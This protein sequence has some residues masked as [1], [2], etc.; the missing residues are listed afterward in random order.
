MEHS[1]G[2]EHPAAVSLGAFAAVGEFPWIGRRR[3]RRGLLA[4][5]RCRKRGQALLGLTRL[6]FPAMLAEAGASATHAPAR[7]YQS[8]STRT[9]RADGTTGVVRHAR[10]HPRPRLRFSA[11]PKGSKPAPDTAARESRRQGDG[12]GCSRP[13]HVVLPRV[14]S[15][16]GRSLCG[17]LSPQIKRRQAR[18]QRGSIPYRTQKTFFIVGFCV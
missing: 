18:T 6:R 4:L 1:A 16:R 2:A 13:E 5:F 8:A 12:R 14:P 11:P 7:F 3:V 9:D 15:R 17:N 10:R